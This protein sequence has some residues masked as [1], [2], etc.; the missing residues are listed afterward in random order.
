[1]V[2]LRFNV[3][4]IWALNCSTFHHFQQAL[5]AKRVTAWQDSRNAFFWLFSKAIVAQMTFSYVDHRFRKDQGRRG[6]A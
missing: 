1:M 5:M 6:L 4:A 2:Q 3:A